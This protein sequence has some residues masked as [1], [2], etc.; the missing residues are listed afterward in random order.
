[1][2]RK[3]FLRLKLLVFVCVCFIFGLCLLVVCVALG[4]F[5]ETIKACFR[6]VYQACFGYLEINFRFC[7]DHG[8]E[9]ELYL[10]REE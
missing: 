6:C 1:M 3:A 7:N 9:F 8:T 5:F 2:N 10:L 4:G